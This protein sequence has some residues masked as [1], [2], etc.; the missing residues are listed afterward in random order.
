MLQ[1]TVRSP[2]YVPGYGRAMCQRK[3]RLQCAA[4]AEGNGISHLCALQGAGI[5]MELNHIQLGVC[6]VNAL[7]FITGGKEDAPAEI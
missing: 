3:W 5:T 4:R 6:A 1:Q 7:N 2:Q